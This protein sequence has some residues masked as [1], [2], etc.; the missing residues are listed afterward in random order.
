M[1][2]FV[3]A[4]EIL[5]VALRIAKENGATKILEINVEA[6]ELTFLNQ[7][8]LSLAFETLS[9]GT[10]AEKAKLKVKVKPCRINCHEC[11]YE[12][13]AH[14]AGPERHDDL[15]V[16]KL[17]LLTCPKCGGKDTEVVGGTEYFIRD[18]TIQ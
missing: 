1:H 7:E 15:E 13:D 17:M 14:Y 4:E 2:E 8:N 9:Q 12:G 3:A 11:G 16:T 6:G 18:I 10:I 5:N